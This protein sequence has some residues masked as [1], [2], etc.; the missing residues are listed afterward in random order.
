MGWAMFT[1]GVVLTDVF[2]CV[3]AAIRDTGGRQPS[4]LQCCSVLFYLAFFWVLRNVEGRLKHRRILG[5]LFWLGSFSY[6]LYLVHG[7]ALGVV[8][9][10]ARR[11]G[12]VGTLYLISYLLQITVA[13]FARWV[14]YLAV[15]RHFNSSRQ[16]QR[17]A[18]G[19][20][21]IA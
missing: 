20:D 11:M 21:V 10:L 8:D 13:V 12:L 1:T 18:N 14:F 16:K 4:R 2:A 3:R 17:I 6:S 7:Y 9:I 15:E 5:P 19:G